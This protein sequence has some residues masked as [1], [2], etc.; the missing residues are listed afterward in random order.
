MSRWLLLGLLCAA[1]APSEN[2]PQG[3]CARRAE[4]DPKVRELVMLS[5]TNQVELLN[6]REDLRLARRDA[7]N[8]CLSDRGIQPP[9]GVEPQRI[10]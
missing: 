6:H 8:R 1:C 5:G 7:V 2:T 10:R 9:G 4:D 3:I